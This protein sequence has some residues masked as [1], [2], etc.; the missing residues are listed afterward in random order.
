MITA[1]DVSMGPPPS[2]PTTIKRIQEVKVD[3]CP[4]TVCHYKGVTYVGL[5]G[6]KVC[7]IDYQ[8]A[9]SASEFAKLNKEICGI[10]ANLD[11]LYILMRGRPYVVFVYDVYGTE[12]HKWDFENQRNLAANAMAIVD[13]QLL[14][15]D[16]S[17]ACI[18]IYSLNGEKQHS[19]PC[20]L[21]GSG[22]NSLCG[23]G[24][25]AIVIAHR[26]SNKVFRVKLSTGEVQW[27]SNSVIEPVGVCQYSD[28]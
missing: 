19:I 26:E 10:I 17:N 28:M 15:A 27:T 12:L 9:A 24:P 3:S 16:N 21:I 23:C 22:Y 14:L 25:D 8:Q 18:T 7:K 1:D 4:R 20:S 11:R 6:G 5:N 2:L 13:N